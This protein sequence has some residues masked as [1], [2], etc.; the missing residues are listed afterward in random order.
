MYSSLA[1]VVRVWLGPP[2]ALFLVI[3][4]HEVGHALAGRLAGHRVRALLIGSGPRLLSFRL[5]RVVVY[6]HALPFSGAVLATPPNV[7]H[8]IRLRQWTMFAGG[9]AANILMFF[10]I[11]AFEGPAAPWRDA[12]SWW[13]SAAMLNLGI[14]LLNLIPF[15]VFRTPLGLPT[16]GQRLLA[17]PFWGRRQ[18]DEVRATGGLTSVL[19][20]ADA[21]DLPAATLLATQLQ[22]HHPE[23]GAAA[24]A[25]ERFSTGPDSWK[26]REPAGCRTCRDRV[27]RPARC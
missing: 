18:V 27:N 23:Q 9:P 3:L 6:L 24:M 5:G 8:W 17:I 1:D 19:D 26:R 15:R 11:R 2:A 12:Q 4:T 13:M 20:A 22:L 25:P 16:D 14:G 10:V 21:G 7:D